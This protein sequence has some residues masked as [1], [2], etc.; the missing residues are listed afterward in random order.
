ML[1]AFA[2]V[3]AKNGF[4]LR[5]PGNPASPM[6]YEYVFV[7]FLVALA[8]MIGGGGNLSIDRLISSRRKRSA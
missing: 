5:A 2:K 1:V 3:H 4:L 8:L 6:G 7:L